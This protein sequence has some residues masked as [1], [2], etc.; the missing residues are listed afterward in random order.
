M[1]TAVWSVL[2]AKKRFLK[3][4]YREGFMAH[5][6]VI[7]EQI[8]PLMAWGFFGTDENLKDICQY[9]R[10]E[11]LDFM[12]DIYD[13]SKVRYTVVEELSEDI[14]KL[15]QSSMPVALNMPTPMIILML[16]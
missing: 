7:S 5:F 15:M 2:K 3:V 4:E 8:S 6:Y 9:F 16:A 1:T 11:M 12:S 13:Y 14:L 10:Q